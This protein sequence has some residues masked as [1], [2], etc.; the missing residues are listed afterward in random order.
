M[1]LKQFYKLQRIC[2]KYITPY[3]SIDKIKPFAIYVCDNN[4]NDIFDILKN[5]IIYYDKSLEINKKVK[6]IIPKIQKLLD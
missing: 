5:N 3:Y 6:K 2:E 1:E 4:G